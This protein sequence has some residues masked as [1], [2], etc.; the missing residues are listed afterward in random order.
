VTSTRFPKWTNVI[1]LPTL[2]LSLSLSLQSTD[3]IVATW[4]HQVIKNR[5]YSVLIPCYSQ[6]GPYM[7]E[8]HQTSLEITQTNSEHKNRILQQKH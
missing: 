2:S 3:F 8:A 7:C 5:A 4:G 6:L 1:I